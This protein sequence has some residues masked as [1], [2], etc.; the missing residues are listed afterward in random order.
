MGERS[1]ALGVIRVAVA[2]PHTPVP[3]ENEKGPTRSSTGARG[4]TMP[5][6]TVFDDR[7]PRRL[8]IMKWIRLGA[9][10]ITGRVGSVTADA[11]TTAAGSSGLA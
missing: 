6:I 3:P 10:G 1:V 2:I 11:V 7:L 4:A 5:W 9:R 8:Y